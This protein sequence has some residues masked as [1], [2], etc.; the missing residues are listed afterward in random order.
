MTSVFAGKNIVIGVT[1]SIA[2][3]KVAG[4]VSDLAKEEAIVSVVMSEAAHHFVAPLTFE[5][6]SGNKVYSQMFE[7]PGSR[8][9]AHIDLGRDADLIVVAPATANTIAKLAAGLADDL[10]TCAVLAARCKVLVFP[11]M[12]SHMYSHPATVSNI[13]RLK[14]M[15]YTVLDPDSGMM[16]CKEVGEGRLVEWDDAKGHLATFLTPQD[17]VNEKVLV[18]AGPTR[19]PIDPARFLSNRSSGKMGYALA[20]AAKRR[21]AEVVLISGPTNLPCP[22]GVNRVVIE[23]A[24]QMYKRTLEEAGNCSIVIKAAAVADFRSENTAVHKEKKEAINTQLSLIKNPDI[25][26]QLGKQKSSNQILVGFA[27]ESRNLLD[28]GRRKL[29]KK[30]L[31]LIAINNI[32]EDQA[33]FEVD[34]NKVILLDK[35][36]SRDLPLTTKLHTADLILDRVLELRGDQ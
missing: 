11:A 23:T 36:S 28:E 12:N 35:D 4:W 9:M 33:G 3:F 7:E 6:L 2:A 30:K 29:E 27:A 20:T 8:S 34:T 17:L 1:G 5:A 10:L 14:E 22:A 25:L 21:G 19:E 15:G 32:S 13:K 31:D 26:Y 24:N 18:T 16:A